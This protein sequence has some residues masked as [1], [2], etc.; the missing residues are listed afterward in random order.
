MPAMRM[1]C[2]LLEA[3]NSFRFTRLSAQ[4]GGYFERHTQKSSPAE[5]PGS[6]S[7]ALAA[8]YFFGALAKRR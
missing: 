2:Y 6:C 7:E 4:N 3:V 5:R 1:P 8:R